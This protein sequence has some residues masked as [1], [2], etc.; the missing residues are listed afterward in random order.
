[1][2]SI[3]TVIV[4]FCYYLKVLLWQGRRDNRGNEMLS[5]VVP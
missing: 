5:E 4:V 2:F 3:E 1:M